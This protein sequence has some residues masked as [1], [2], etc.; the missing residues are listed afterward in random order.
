MVDAADMIGAVGV[1]SE[2]M[3]SGHRYCGSPRRLHRA[4]HCRM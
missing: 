3:K 1:S 4:Y 2:E